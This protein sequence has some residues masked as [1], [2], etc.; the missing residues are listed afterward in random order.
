MNPLLKK[1]AAAIAIK[2]GIEKI[3]EMRRP[4]RRSLKRRLSK[5]LLLLCAAGGAGYL[6][7]SGKLDS[8]LGKA[9]ASGE[10]SSGLSNDAPSTDGQSGDRL[11]SSSSPTT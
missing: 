11:T 8:L 9:R 6:Y 7:K 5:P 10:R 3:Q 1:V 4:R 2:E